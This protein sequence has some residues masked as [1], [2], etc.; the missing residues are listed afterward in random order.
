M[1]NDIQAAGKRS[2]PS[3]RPAEDDDAAGAEDGVG[4]E[5]LDYVV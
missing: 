4:I 2:C 3:T 5:L 1:F